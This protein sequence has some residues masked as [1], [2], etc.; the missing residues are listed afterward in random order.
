MRLRSHS[1]LHQYIVYTLTKRDDCCIGQ[2]G[3]LYEA[4]GEL[5]PKGVIPCAIITAAR[6][7]STGRIFVTKLINVYYQTLSLAVVSVEVPFQCLEHLFA[8]RKMR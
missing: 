1:I 7:R 4:F 6:I 3:I 8:M 2:R 5:E